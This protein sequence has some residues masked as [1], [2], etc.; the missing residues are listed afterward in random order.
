[1]LKNEFSVYGIILFAFANYEFSGR[2]DRFCC[3]NLS[4]AIFWS[5][6]DELSLL[7]LSLTISC[8]LLCHWRW[9][10]SCHVVTRCFLSL[11][12]PSCIPISFAIHHNF[13][14]CLFLI[15]QG[16]LWT[17]FYKESLSDTIWSCLFWRF[18]L[19]SVPSWFKHF[20]VSFASCLHRK[21]QYFYLHLYVP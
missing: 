10:G 9:V 2:K 6:D 3:Y 15:W 8:F 4:F 16:V 5:T 12:M 19:L 17:V 21:C 1:M 11:M 14:V 20:L 7:M 13:C 18:W